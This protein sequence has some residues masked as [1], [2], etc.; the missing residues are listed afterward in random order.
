MDP[1]VQHRLLGATLIVIVTFLL[2]LH[3]ATSKYL[4]AFFAVPMLVW[5]RYVGHLLIML[6][7][8]APRMGREIIVTS[9]PSL[10]VM[11][12]VMLV[13]VSLLVQSALKTLPLAETSALVFVT[14]L[15]VAVLAGPILGER[16]HART[17]IAIA[18]GFGGT[19]LIARP[20]GVMPLRGVVFGLGAA[21]CY[22]IYQLFTRK[23]AATEPPMRQ[24]FYTALIG[25][26]VTSLIVPA[27]LTPVLP[28]LSQ[29]LLIVSLSLSAAAGHFLFIRAAQ[30]TPASTLSTLLYLQL[31]WTVVLGWLVF[32][33]LPDLPSLLGMLVIGASSLSIA[34]QKH[35]PAPEIMPSDELPG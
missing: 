5:S 20:G 27:Y 25:S 18:A 1:I 11:R 29:G 8:V 28:T 6:V 22:A 15:I 14:P 23:L 7:G 26:I 16:I 13:A 31:P 35:A 4:T 30:E 17:W 33:H 10:M 24:L 2:A 3:D 9:H 12:G 19:L 32:D 34:L 21:L